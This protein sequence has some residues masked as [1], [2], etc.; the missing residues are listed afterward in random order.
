[1][2]AERAEAVRQGMLHAWRSYERFAMGAAELRPISKMAKNDIMGGAGISGLGVTV[3]DAM[4][5]LYIM[6]YKEEFER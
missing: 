6:G 5:T 1:M 2:A 3:V 4:S